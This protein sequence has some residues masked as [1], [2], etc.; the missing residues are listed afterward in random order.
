MFSW[1]QH[2]RKIYLCSCRI[3]LQKRG[4]AEKGLQ[5]AVGSRGAGEGRRSRPQQQKGAGSKGAESA[6]AAGAPAVAG[7]AGSSR[8]QDLSFFVL[9]PFCLCRLGLVLMELGHLRW[10]R[11]MD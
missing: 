2:R 1:L 10:V 5:A 4:G 11:E 6:A 7:G 8:A 3:W 9:F